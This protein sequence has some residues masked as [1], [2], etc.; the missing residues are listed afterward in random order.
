[1]F[2]FVSNLSFFVWLCLCTLNGGGESTFAVA[3]IIKSP[4]KNSFYKTPLTLDNEWRC[5]ILHSEKSERS[6]AY[7]ISSHSFSCM[8]SHHCHPYPSFAINALSL[9]KC[10]IWFTKLDARVPDHIDHTFKI[11]PEGVRDGTK[12][13]SLL[14]ACKRCNW[15]VCYLTTSSVTKIMWR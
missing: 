9:I 11:Q 14:T 15:Y 4:S 7:W 13:I 10:T 6:L 3:F 12:I 8:R 2:S 5:F 1:M